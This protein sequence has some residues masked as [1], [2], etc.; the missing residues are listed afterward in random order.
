MTRRLFVKK[1]MGQGYSRNAANH[2]AERWPKDE[3]Y[4]WLYRRYTGEPFGMRTVRIFNE[5]SVSAK[6]FAVALSANSRHMDNT[7][8]ALHCGAK[9]DEEEP[10]A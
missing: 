4:E 7:R 8:K 1:M 2:I 9:M 10:N 6:Q 3:P 5:F